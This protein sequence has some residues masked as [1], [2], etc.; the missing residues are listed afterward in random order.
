LSFLAPQESV[1][2]QDLVCGAGNLLFLNTTANSRSP[3]AHPRAWESTL[4]VA[5]RGMTVARGRHSEVVYSNCKEPVGTFSTS[6]QKN[7]RRR[8]AYGWREHLIREGE[9]P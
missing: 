6:L 7:A 4:H 9:T 1:A 5:L 8:E 2:C 3:G